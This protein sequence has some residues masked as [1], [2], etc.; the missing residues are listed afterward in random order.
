MKKTAEKETSKP[1]S[2]FSFLIQ[3][4]F[5]PLEN[6]TEGFLRT[7]DPKN[8]ITYA[9]VGKEKGGDT[10]NEHYHV[11]VRTSKQQRNSYFFNR[12][13]EFQVP[14]HMDERVVNTKQAIDYIGNPDFVYSDKHPD[15]NKRGKKK[16]GECLWIKEIGDAT[17]VRLPKPGTMGN[18][19]NTRLETIRALVDEGKTLIDLYN[20][21]FPLMVKYGRQIK[22]YIQTLNDET[23][24]AAHMLMVGRT[25]TELQAKHRQE[26]D[27]L[28][29]QFNRMISS[30]TAIQ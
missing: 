25:T 22:D 18:D 26:I 23:A 4:E 19:V 21:D 14:F 15:S 2:F 10:N 6:D 20:A 13:R 16:G 12:L 30:G 7:L 29:Q 28:T 17:T 27:E 11:F 1:T 5:S 24:I 9:K 8:L 3:G